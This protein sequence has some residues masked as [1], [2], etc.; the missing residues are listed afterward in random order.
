VNFSSFKLD[1]KN[2]AN[3]DAVSSKRANFDEV[4]FSTKR[5][6]KLIIFGTHNLQIFTH[7]TLI[8]ELLLMQFYL[9]CVD[10]SDENYASHCSELSQLH[11][12]PVD[13]VLRPTFIQKLCYKL[14]SIVTF[15]FIQT[16]DQNDVFFTEWHHVDRQCD[17]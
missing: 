13:A 9:N 6:S 8:N 16:F 10:R 1:A 7:N 2:N 12:Q 4:K 14:P 17:A 5:T 15:T 3:F 11:Q